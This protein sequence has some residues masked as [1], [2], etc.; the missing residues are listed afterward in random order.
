MAKF[1]SEVTISRKKKK[2]KTLDKRRKPLATGR[3]GCTAT[4]F[5]R[6]RLVVHK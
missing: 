4:A 5:E 2:K 1:R 3:M 6:T